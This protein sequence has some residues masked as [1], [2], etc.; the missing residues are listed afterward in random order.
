MSSLKEHEFVHRYRGGSRI[1][2]LGGP[3]SS[4]QK[5]GWSGAYTPGKILKFRGQI[6]RHL[7]LQ[8]SVK[9][10]LVLLYFLQN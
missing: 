9:T 7:A 2:K 8:L 5:V 4:D 3:T 1:L 6:G 10:K